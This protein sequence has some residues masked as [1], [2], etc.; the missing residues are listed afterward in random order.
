MLNFSF[1]Q[2]CFYCE[3]N[4]ATRYDTIDELHN[5]QDET[6]HIG[7]QVQNDS[8]FM[9]FYVCVESFARVRELKVHKLHRKHENPKALHEKRMKFDELIQQKFGL[10]ITILALQTLAPKEWVDDDITNFYLK[11]I[12]E[13]NKNQENVHKAHIMYTNTMQ[14][15]KA[16]IDKN[17]E[18]FGRED[19]ITQMASAFASLTL[20]FDTDLFAED[21]V[22]VPI[23]SNGNHWTLLVAYPEAR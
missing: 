23:H 19:R 8:K 14:L 13:H 4:C 12:E 22:L 9:C 10:S 1:F 15:L 2:R 7:H 16:E 17:E 21:V 20:R 18:A 11:L 6:D 5:H 3:Y